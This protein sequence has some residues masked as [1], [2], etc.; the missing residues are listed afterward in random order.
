MGGEVVEAVDLA[1]VSHADGHAVGAELGVLEAGGV[2]VHGLDGLQG[3]GAAFD[4]ALRQVPDV[5]A[6][7]AG[8]VDHVQVG[9][10][11]GVADGAP[12]AADGLQAG[13]DD[14]GGARFVEGLAQIGAEEIIVL[15]ALRNVPFQTP[16]LVLLRVG[17]DVVQEA[18]LVDAGDGEHHGHG[19]HALFG[20]HAVRRARVMSDVGVA[21][22]VDDD[23]REDRAGA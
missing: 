7:V 11:A 1:G 18:L 23:L 3:L 20:R 9:G 4:F 19:Q 8:Q 16:I 21:G 22:R 13:R 10:F 12:G 15:A 6:V 14:A 5:G 17:G 2:V